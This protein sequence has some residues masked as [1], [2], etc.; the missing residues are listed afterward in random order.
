M[1]DG[2][3]FRE[4]PVSGSH[5]CAVVESE[6]RQRW[7]FQASVIVNDLWLGGFIFGGVP[8]KV[9]CRRE[10]FDGNAWVVIVSKTTLHWEQGLADLPAKRPPLY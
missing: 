9:C 7:R 1:L 6:G 2:D 8:H 10:D 3:A 5:V 4:N